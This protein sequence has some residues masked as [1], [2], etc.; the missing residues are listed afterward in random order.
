[1]MGERGSGGEGVACSRDTSKLSLW[2]P[3]VPGQKKDIQ[4]KND[5]GLRANLQ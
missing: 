4:I 2:G 5:H 1:M 3:T